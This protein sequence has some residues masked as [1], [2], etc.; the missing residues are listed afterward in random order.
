M[1]TPALVAA[2]DSPSGW[3]R[4]A[5]Q[6]LLVQRRD[7]TAVAPLE[8]LAGSSARPQARLHALGTL[9]LLG[10]LQA[11][12]LVRA[13]ADP[14][15]GVRAN[16]L[17]LA[18][19]FDSPTVIAAA[20]R[21]TADPDPKVRLQLA[22]TLGAWKSA[23]A[24]QALGA[25]LV[26]HH[27]DPH[28]KAAAMTSLHAENIA[29]VIA[30]ASP[31]AGEAPLE[32]LLEQGVGLGRLDAVVRSLETVLD[33]APAEGDV[34]TLKLLGAAI[35]AAERRGISLEALGENAAR[36]AAFRATVANRI[37]QAA[38]L[39]FDDAAAEDVRAA[40][41]ALVGRGLPADPK[42]PALAALLSPHTASQIQRAVVARLGASTL[43]DA[44]ALLLE[45][46]RS[47]T[48]EV[49][50]AIVDVILRRS[51]WTAALL[52]AIEQQTVR[53]ADL[54]S[55]ARQ[56]LS[57]VGDADLRARAEKLLAASSEASRREVLARYQSALTL[58]GD[59][60]RGAQLFKAKCAVCHRLHDVGNEVGPNL[61]SLTDKSPGTLLTA[62][63]DPS[64]AVEARYLNFV[65]VTHDGV[66]VSGL[67]QSETGASVTL[68]G[69]NGQRTSVLRAD[70][71]SLQSTGKSMMPDG[72]ENE[73]SPQDVAD[74]MRHIVAPPEPPAPR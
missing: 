63:L 14:A 71:D 58:P 41:I 17:R 9:E 40:A 1:T 16:A 21:L 32:E 5:A 23:S 53:P 65:A 35:G 30:A 68:V 50:A 3:Q 2:L 55:V 47:H 60:A 43:P 13:F 56:R 33:S 66:A 31:P 46:W 52:E 10:R 12:V 67:V 25:L 22:F 62:I 6:Q 27:A 7:E 20:A 38:E 57:A 44:G 37:D 74:I 19:S 24:A 48:P 18:E 39:A 49:R 70:L 15:A 26:E 73:L 51:E 42:V 4:D 69:Q 59:A 45:D 72:L 54:D 64:Q 61:A 8:A 36:P 11:D 34:T 28:L 29:S